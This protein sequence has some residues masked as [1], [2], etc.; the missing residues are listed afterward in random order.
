MHDF[1]ALD[2]NIAWSIQNFSESKVKKLT[3]SC[4]R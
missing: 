1:D 2:L 4:N 3:E